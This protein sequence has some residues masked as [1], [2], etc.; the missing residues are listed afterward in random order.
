M[1]MPD[2]NSAA[3]L[4]N[5][6]ACS[7]EARAIDAYYHQATQDY[8]DILFT[9]PRKARQLLHGPDVDTLLDA[10]FD[11][12]SDAIGDGMSE[13]RTAVAE[14][15]WEEVGWVVLRAFERLAEHLAESDSGQ[16]W[17]TDRALEKYNQE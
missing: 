6:A 1:R 4:V 2:G 13:L 11:D 8:L 16:R 5:D 17:I 3:E 12:P 9:L 14:Q 7:R 15:D 10:F